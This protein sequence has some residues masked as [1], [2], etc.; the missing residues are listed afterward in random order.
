MSTT[1]DMGSAFS[2]HGQLS[3]LS[4]HLSLDAPRWPP[5][6]SMFYSGHEKD[7]CIGGTGR[8]LAQKSSVEFKGGAA[9]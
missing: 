6:R 7:G 8:S 1:L 2:S 9:C 4:L 3:S 5:V